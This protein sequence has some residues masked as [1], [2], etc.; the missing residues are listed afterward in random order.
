MAR[1]K[2]RCGEVLSN[3]LVPNNIELWVYTDKEWDDIMTVDT[4][5]TW[6]FPSPTYDVWKCPKCQRIYVFEEHNNKAVKVYKLED[7]K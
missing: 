3:S 7:Q 1:L 2:C 6:E 5:N 4:I